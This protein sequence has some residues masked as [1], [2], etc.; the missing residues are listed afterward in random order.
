[1][2]EPTPPPDPD[3][4]ALRAYARWTAEVPEDFLAVHLAAAL[5]DL[6]R[7]TGLTA[8][9]EGQAE[10]WAEARLARA[11]ALALPFLHTFTVDGAARVGRLMGNA[12]FEFLTAAEALALAGRQDERY[13]RLVDGLT[14]DATD[15]PSV[16]H[17][18]RFTWVNL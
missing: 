16:A 3:V 9:P 5:R 15:A 1:M 2:S 18:G 11:Y 8:A 6:Q 17:G 13:R 7:D 14:P 4:V 10:A 12:E